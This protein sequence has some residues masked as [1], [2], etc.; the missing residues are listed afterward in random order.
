MKKNY[1]YFLLILVLII[2]LFISLMPNII[3]GTETFAGGDSYSYYGRAN[4]YYYREINI[5]ESYVYPREPDPYPP[6]IS[7]LIA[8]VKFL[9]DCNTFIIDIIMRMI[10]SITTVFLLFLIGNK[11]SPL[12]GI[13]SSYL[14]ILSTS[15]ITLLGGGSL[16]TYYL[17]SDIGTSNYNQSTIFFLVAFI[18]YTFLLQKIK[19]SEVGVV[20]YYLLLF[21]SF[22][23]EGISH[24][25]LF[26]YD[27]ILYIILIISMPFIL[28]FRSPRIWKYSL[29][30]GLIIILTAICTLSLLSQILF[31]SGVQFDFLQ[32]IS[33]TTQAINIYLILMILVLIIFISKFYNVTT[34][35]D[36]GYINSFR[37][38]SKFYKQI[39]L[40][41]YIVTYGLAII[42]ITIIGPEKMVP[43][44]WSHPF[45]IYYGPP[46][47]IFTLIS[48]G[49]GFSFFCVSVAAMY[50][51]IEKRTELNT[52]LSI[53]WIL[54]LI[55]SISPLLI[56]NILGYRMNLGLSAL[57]PLFL[58]QGLFFIIMYVR[59]AYRNNKILAR[60][61]I[62]TIL[63]AIII[64]PFMASMVMINTGTSI[65]DNTS[66]FPLL[67][68]TP[69]TENEME[70]TPTLL[71][72]IEENSKNG[73][74][75]LCCPNDQ[76]ILSAMTH[77]KPM[78]IPVALA[79]APESKLDNIR[80]QNVYS[81]MQLKQNS[82]DN[83]EKDFTYKL[84]LTTK[85]SQNNPKISW[86]LYEKPP[87]NNE[88]Y[89]NSSNI[90]KIFEDGYG[91]YVYLI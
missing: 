37:W 24:F 55:L 80:I 71:H 19:N 83:L 28:L 7:I 75:I 89:Q 9:T 73:E 78:C 1:T 61:I 34:N 20:P 43:T 17:I 48:K 12:I 10:S 30:V 79:I 38:I 3:L 32:T 77:I 18:S 72:Y 45:G 16:I 35:P 90:F 6:G 70:L 47:N 85:Y 82:L 25:S 54:C 29:I 33:T 5:T 64:F 52:V 81:A 65:R 4:G 8:N 53:T 39:I 67:I 26:G 86:L 76:W 2:N 21:L 36:Y 13:G 46:Y 59:T 11:L 62:S 87:M 88:D 69:N 51:L 14:K 15:S 91:E 56:T 41:L 22:F 50:I 68:T 40:S 31:L 49:L 63:S 60:I 23:T 44:A 58:A 42:L 74:S 66:N 84:L 57:L 27:M